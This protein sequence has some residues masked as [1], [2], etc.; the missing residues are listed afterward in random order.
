MMYIFKKT[1]RYQIIP[2]MISVLSIQTYANAFTTSSVFDVASYSDIVYIQELESLHLYLT[3]DN[4]RQARNDAEANPKATSIIAQNVEVCVLSNNIEGMFLNVAPTSYGTISA[5]QAGKRQDKK[6]NGDKLLFYNRDQDHSLPFFLRVTPN[7]EA[8]GVNL[9]GRKDD[10]TISG[11]EAPYGSLL[12]NLQAGRDGKID[13]FDQKSSYADTYK[14]N[15]NGCTG[16]PIRYNIEI[17]SSDIA[18][19]RA[20]RYMTAFT[21]SVK[22]I[23]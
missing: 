10:F 12:Y 17:M 4:I 19:A 23:S 11:S 1:M 22:S 8:E 9:L 3:E 18:K 14:N 2:M 5:Q 20:G 21:I 16:G 7:R 13:H 6:T 15:G